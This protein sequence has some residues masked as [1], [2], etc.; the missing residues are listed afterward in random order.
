MS[1]R[2]LHERAAALFL[3]AR[4]RPPGERD[5]FLRRAAGGDER[6]LDEA[7]T[8]LAHDLDIDAGGLTAS[9]EHAGGAGPA[10]SPAPVRIGPYRVI[11]R[12]GR[13][14]SGYVLL[15][16]QEQ[17]IRRRV[18]I[19]IV[20][21]AAID[22]DSAAR[23]DIERRA[24]ER[25]DHPNIARILDAGRTP[26]GLPYLVMEYVEGSP[27]TEHCRR[28][29]APLRDRIR[30]MLDVADAVQHAHARGVIHRDLK[31]ANILVSAPD[32]QERPAGP[33]GR[34]A[35]RSAARP[36]L[37]DFGIAKPVADTDGFTGQAP[38]TMG[39]PLGTPAYMAPEQ[40][41]GGAAVDTR[42]DVYALGAVLYELACGRPPI[43]AGAGGANAIDAV[44][45]S[46]PAPASRVRAEHVRA[47]TFPG[48]HAPRSLLADLDCVLAHALE[49]S[50]DRRYPTASAFA[51][52]LRRLLKREPIA[53]SPPTWRYRATRFAQR[54]RLLLAAAAAVLAAAVTGLV[55][56]TLGLVEARRQQREALAQGE[57]QR[58]I[59]RF[60]TDDLL[61]AA[62]PEE[63]GQH[64]TALDLLHR[65]GARVEERFA[66]RPLVAA[67]I[68]HTLGVTYGTLGAFDDAE[69][70]LERA[71]D[72][73]RAAAGANAPDTVR[74]EIA[75]ASLLA[76]RQRLEEADAALTGVIRRARL[77]LAP[78]DAA[79]LTAL[80]DLGS[81]RETQ[82]RA[83]EAIGLLQEALAGRIQA[84]G[85]RD[86]HVLMT[87][88]N[89]AMAY[90][91]KGDTERSLQMQID[92]LRLADSIEPAPRMT[93]IGL[94]NNVG[95]TYQDLNRDREA[96]PYLARAADLA[97]EWLGDDHPD[98]L[99]IRANLAGLKAELGE[100]AQA[101]ALLD[102][103]VTVRAR[104]LGPA[105]WDTL[106]ARY[107]Y[108]NAMYKA[109]RFGEAVDGY[110]A[111]LPDVAA[112]LGDEHW[113][114]AQS[115]AALAL[116]LLDAGRLDE[117]LPHAER[118]A[119]Q[120][121]S[122]YG[123]EHARTKNAAATLQSIRTG[124]ESASAGNGPP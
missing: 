9:G 96:E 76:Q 115:R 33:P 5:R 25:T 37:V 14:G 62:S 47:G 110:V 107:A 72:L 88:S 10:A 70:H 54:N 82:D 48:D 24:L 63:E 121:T 118:A 41:G 44:R 2:E 15:A 56:L 86:P 84:L 4:G 35:R 26:D 49:K 97:R 12:I 65:A 3:E 21:H 99:T 52:D 100:P 93:L 20:P 104:T 34:P 95:A 17:P 55:G 124:M 19:K 92:A 114:M 16:E 77:I 27:I 40:A 106:T 108:W 46:I 85:P 18:A 68:H 90:D 32:P 58:E 78:G 103:V 61:A 60:L 13:G 11:E 81:L 50:P 111:F 22:A 120:F 23:F 89:L 67:S 36:K 122:L 29:R 83:E 39:L 94:C 31:P 71:I 51:D 6:L 116:A 73:R 74:S 119:A 28:N 87:M 43:D 7:R 53:A 91:R 8:L 75:A 123:P 105:A 112:G 79:L 42:A 102:D 109:K 30:L 64:I 57:A 1:D 45:R 113:L 80:N 101:M 69:R 38:Q 117:A 59:N 66:A 98:A